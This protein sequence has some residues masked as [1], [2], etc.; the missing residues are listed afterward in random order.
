MYGWFNEGFEVW[1]GYPY[2]IMSC[3]QKDT[4]Y[5]QSIII[6]LWH[7]HLCFYNC[8]IIMIGISLIL[9]SVK[10]RVSGAGKT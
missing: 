10:C 6:V 4:G 9:Y 8:I 5:S 7:S 1:L 3:M 2:V